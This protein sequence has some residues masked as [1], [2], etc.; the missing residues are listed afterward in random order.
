MQFVFK[1]STVTKPA[2]AH[3]NGCRHGAGQGNFAHRRTPA[4]TWH[5]ARRILVTYCHG[6]QS[7]LL[8]GQEIEASKKQGKGDKTAPEGQWGSKG[9]PSRHGCTRHGLYNFPRAIC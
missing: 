2:R 3:A 4:A 7:D 1:R 9:Q 5:M 6:S 8:P